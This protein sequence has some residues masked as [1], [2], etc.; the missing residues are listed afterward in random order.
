MASLT[1]SV[2]GSMSAAGSK[3]SIVTDALLGLGILA[4]DPSGFLTCTQQPF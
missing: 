3:A 2:V 1:D 4:S